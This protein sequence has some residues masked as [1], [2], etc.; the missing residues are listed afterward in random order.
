MAAPPTI[1]VMMPPATPAANSI[2]MMCSAMRA[3]HSVAPLFP[4]PGVAS[5]DQKNA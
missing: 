3:M 4:A 5:G 2:R 1:D